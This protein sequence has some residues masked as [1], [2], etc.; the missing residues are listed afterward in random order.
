MRLDDL[1]QLG[2]HV[3]AADSFAAA[4]DA[5]R[6][7]CAVG[8]CARHDVAQVGVSAP[9]R[10]ASKAAGVNDLAERSAFARLRGSCGDKARRALVKT[11]VEQSEEFQIGAR[12]PTPRA[13]RQIF[14][15]VLK[16]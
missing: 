7:N 5:P 15:M 2:L 8:P 14:V 10:D 12:C 9:D 1:L 3:T 11:P 6:P 4:A 13:N 16:C